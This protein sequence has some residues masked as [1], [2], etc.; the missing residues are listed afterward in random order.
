MSTRAI[1]TWWKLLYDIETSVNLPPVEAV[2]FSSASSLLSKLPRQYGTPVSLL[3]DVGFKEFLLSGRKQLCDPV[4]VALY[5]DPLQWDTFDGLCTH[6]ASFLRS[7]TKELDQATVLTPMQAEKKRKNDNCARMVKKVKLCV[8]SKTVPLVERVMQLM[9]ARHDRSA[10]GDIVVFDLVLLPWLCLNLLHYDPFTDPPEKSYIN[11]PWFIF[12]FSTPTAHY[13]LAL[14]HKHVIYN[15]QCCSN[16][17]FDPPSFPGKDCWFLECAIRL[18]IMKKALN[19]G[20][21]RIGRHNC[22]ALPM[23]TIPSRDCPN[24]RINCPCYSVMLSLMEELLEIIPDIV[25]VQELYAKFESMQ[26]TSV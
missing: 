6:H 4:C 7:D 10:A 12:P 16:N 14:L 15:W 25:G 26:V 18:T 9:V 17:F 3:I 11:P 19:A 13:G 24:L 23:V 22:Y 8:N 2:Q 1:H 21:P 5:H 20:L